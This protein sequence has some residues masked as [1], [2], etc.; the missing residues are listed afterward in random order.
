MKTEGVAAGREER[1]EKRGSAFPQGAGHESCRTR[2][3]L[4]AQQNTLLWV[5]FAVWVML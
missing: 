4:D 3:N 5:R 2:E 1:T